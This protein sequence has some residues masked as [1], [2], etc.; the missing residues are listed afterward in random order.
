MSILDFHDDRADFYFLDRPGRQLARRWFGPALL[1]PFL[2]GF[3]ALLLHA[4]AIVRHGRTAVFLAPDEGGK[5]T[6]VR[7]ATDGAVLG[8]DQVLLRRTRGRFQVWGTPWGLHVNAKEHAAL[9]GLFLLKK[10]DGFN[11]ESMPALDLV[12][13]V[14]EEIKDPLSLLPKPS[15]KKAFELV[16][17]IAAA[18]PAWKMS[19]AKSRIDWEAVDRALGPAKNRRTQEPGRRRRATYGIGK[20]V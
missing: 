11:L 16:C 15:I 17:A 5:T 13:H 2:P 7:L 20:R 19:F 9:A 1:A 14:W 18:A 6:A 4:S 12:P 8:D 10:A 3:D